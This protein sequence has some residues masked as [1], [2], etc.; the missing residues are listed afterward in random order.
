MPDYVPIQDLTIV[1]SI[2]NNDLFPLS[3]G[4]GAY[5]VRGS[6]I[7]SYAAT[8]AAAAAADAALSKTA[9]QDAAA[10]AAAAQIAAEEAASGAEASE[11]VANAAMA[12]VRNL[13]H[14]VGFD[15]TLVIG[16]TWNSSGSTASNTK[17]ARSAKRNPHLPRE[18]GVSGQTYLINA[19]GW[20]APDHVYGYLASDWTNERIMIPSTLAAFAIVIKRADDAVIASSEEDAIKDA[21][22]LYYLVDEDFGIRGAPADSLAIKNKLYKSCVVKVKLEH[23]VLETPNTDLYKGWLFDNELRSPGFFTHMRTPNMIDVSKVLTLTLSSEYDSYRIYE[24]AGDFSF[25]QAV[26]LSDG[27]YSVPNGVSYIRAVCFNTGKGTIDDIDSVLTVTAV[28]DA[29]IVYSP[30]SRG[31]NT[32]AMQFVVRGNV[33]NCD[34][35][36]AKSA[37]VDSNALIRLPPNYDPLGDPVPLIVYM[38]GTTGYRQK[39]Q[40]QL[41]IWNSTNP[42]SDSQLKFDIVNY[43]TNEGFA[44]MSIFGHSSDAPYVDNYAYP[45]GNKDQM[46]CIATALERVMSVYNL[47]KTGIFIDGLSAGGVSSI[48]YLLWGNFPVRACSLQAPTISVTR[49]GLGQSES[50][51]KEWAWANGLVGDTDVLNGK[52]GENPWAMSLPAITQDLIDYLEAN[53]DK[54]NGYNPMWDGVVGV[55]QDTLNTWALTPNGNYLGAGDDDPTNWEN[56]SRVAQ[57][58]IC[59]WVANDDTNIDPAL[60]HNYIKTLRNGHSVVEEV[61]IPNGQGGHSAFGDSETVPHVSGTTAL[62]IEYE[63]I[64][65]PWV[66]MVRFFREH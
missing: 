43:L 21:L 35:E 3:D 57:T 14:E 47:D 39:W 27:N 40:Y 62:G 63:G 18:V 49:K 61:I 11:T 48:N 33:Y 19:L 7:K 5:A 38:H 65:W 32:T 4:S 31:T 56:V 53:I 30:N 25:L 51:R 17:R 37:L 8:N 52:N 44:V 36:G 55:P 60:C 29:K 6:T 34:L 50:N 24:Y 58:P 26:D 1:G 46:K 20:D 12:N 9:A 15:G 59:L 41:V 13:L 42:S 16:Q 22:S 66:D 10:D 64:P 54:I 45:Y 28:G 23:G 2:G